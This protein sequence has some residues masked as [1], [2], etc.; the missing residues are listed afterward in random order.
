MSYLMI[1]DKRAWNST[2]TFNNINWLQYSRIWLT[3]KL[4]NNAFLT[5]NFSTT[6]TTIT[7]FNYRLLMIIH[8]L[9]IKRQLY[10]R[11]SV[12]I[13]ILYYIILMSAVSGLNLLLLKAWQHLIVCALT[14]TFSPSIMTSLNLCLWVVS[15][16]S[17]PAVLCSLKCLLTLLE[18]TLSMMSSCSL[19]CSGWT[20]LCSENLLHFNSLTFLKKWWLMMINDDK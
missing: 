2:Q 20:F 19:W 5:S 8:H 10:I 15:L 18:P 9:I 12:S 4:L 7:F 6:V 14:S 3:L 16:L 17:A 1:A 13:K 11:L